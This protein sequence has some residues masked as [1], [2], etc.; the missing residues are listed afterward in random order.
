M[1]GGTWGPN[2]MLLT[3]P[4]WAI[5]EPCTG[6]S[7]AY[8][9]GNLCIVNPVHKTGLSWVPKLSSFSFHS[10]LWPIIHTPF[11]TMH[12][13]KSNNLSEVPGLPGHDQALTIMYPAVLG[14]GGGGQNC[15]VLHGCEG[16]TV[17]RV[18]MIS[19]RIFSGS[20]RW[21]ILF[22]KDSLW[23][24]SLFVWKV[25]TALRFYTGCPR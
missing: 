15:L 17:A 22:D 14:G 25:T 21:K 13:L 20:H 11:C 2:Q 9:L 10:A 23:L 19:K 1:P 3:L 7:P 6:M 5:S 12:G 4:L 24:F 16:D 18:P 8:S